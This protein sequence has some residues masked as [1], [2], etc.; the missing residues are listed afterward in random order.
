MS[1]VVPSGAR[2]RV[3]TERLVPL[4]VTVSVNS[5]PGGAVSGSMLSYRPGR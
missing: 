5:Q 3:T 2:T 4:S 1:P